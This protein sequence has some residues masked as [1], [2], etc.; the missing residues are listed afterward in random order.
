[1]AWLDISNAYGS[2][3]HKMVALLMELHNSGAVSWTITTHSGLHMPLGLPLLTGII[4]RKGLSLASPLFAL[5][6]TMLVKSADV[7]CR[8]PF[9]KYCI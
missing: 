7:K 5:A 3:P 6:M 2:I 1:M 4:W 9:T 8:G